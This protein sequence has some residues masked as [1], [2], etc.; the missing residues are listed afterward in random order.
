MFDGAHLSEQ[1]VVVVT[2]NYRL[3]V[4]GFLAHPDL[5]RESKHNSSGNYGLLDQLG[6]LRWVQ[7]NIARFGGDPGKVTIFGQS[8]GGMSVMSWLASPLAHGLVARAI[9]ES[10]SIMT[11][12][13]RLK[14]AE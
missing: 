3:G 5:T 8:A 14:E 12:L 13:P 4:L 7:K 9:I 10:G 6:A 2:I 11:P 1:G